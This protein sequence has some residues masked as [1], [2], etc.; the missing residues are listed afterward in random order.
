MMNGSTTSNC[1]D[2]F[3]DKTAHMFGLVGDKMISQDISEIY[4]ILVF[5]LQGFDVTVIERGSDF[6]VLDEVGIRG[7]RSNLLF[8][9][10]DFGNWVSFRILIWQIPLLIFEKLNVGIVELNSD[11]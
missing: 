5:H 6:G 2:A 9:I 3:Y 11:K 7:K 1:T 4:C 8:F 10:M